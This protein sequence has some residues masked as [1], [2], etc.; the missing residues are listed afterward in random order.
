MSELQTSFDPTATVR[1]NATRVGKLREFGH[2]VSRRPGVLI[3]LVIVSISFFLAIFGPYIGPYPTETALPGPPLQ[4]PSFQHVMGTD[5]SNMDIFSRVIAAPRIDLTIALVSTAIAFSLGL[6]LGVISGFFATGTGP[7]RF[8]SEIIMRG[9]DII[10]AF[11]VFIFALALVGFRGPGA[12]N[13]IAALAFLNIPF[14]LRITRG[15]VLQVRERPFI[16]AARCA[17]NSEWRIAF[18]HI[19]P[20]AL[21]PPVANISPTIGFSILLTSGL[22]FVGA[23]VP[24]PTPEWGSMIAIGAPNMM[25]GQWWT[26]LFPGLALGITVFGFALAGDGL[27][28]FLDPVK[29][30]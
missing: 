14:F 27:K 25:T 2:F 10:Q 22:S 5:V 1:V 21:T 19:L 23:G 26:A 3:G 12:I 15:A 13:V 4:P 30:S 18:F 28:E 8:A 16:E 6:V 24:V 9:A 29:K 11:P 20:N 17:G 7:A